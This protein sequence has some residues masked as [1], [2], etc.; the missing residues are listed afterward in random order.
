MLNGSARG[1]SRSSSTHQQQEGWYRSDHR[2]AHAN[3]GRPLA[4][5]RSGSHF[6]LEQLPP[7]GIRTQ[8][9]RYRRPFSGIK[10]LKVPGVRSL[11]ELATQ[12][13]KILY[14]LV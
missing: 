1:S 3:S 5:N 12:L 10:S 9:P 7:E 11:F 13:I 6:C 14:G 2:M 4:G 8:A